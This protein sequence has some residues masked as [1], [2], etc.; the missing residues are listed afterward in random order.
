MKFEE[1]LEGDNSL[2]ILNQNI[3]RKSNAAFIYGHE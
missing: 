3:L 1:P 2:K